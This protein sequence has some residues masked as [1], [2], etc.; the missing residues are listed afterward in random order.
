MN[1]KFTQF[2]ISFVKWLSYSLC[3]FKFQLISD[4]LSH[5]CFKINAKFNEIFY[6][7]LVIHMAIISQNLQKNWFNFLFPLVFQI[8]TNI[9][10]IFA[11][12]IQFFIFSFFLFKF[13]V[14]SR[15]LFYSHLF[16]LF[17]ECNV[18]YSIFY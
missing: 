15:S 16:I 13:S 4:F 14:V 9:S 8:A 1:S 2:I 3:N 10:R 6:F 12:S 5:H 11:D 18:I 17:H 7:N